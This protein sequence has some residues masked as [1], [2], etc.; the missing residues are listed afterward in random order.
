[1]IKKSANDYINS[2]DLPEDVKSR[3]IES[4]NVAPMPRTA[5]GKH[6]S[7]NLEEYPNSKIIRW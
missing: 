3:M 1:M 7:L 6:I 4:I 5:L 2:L